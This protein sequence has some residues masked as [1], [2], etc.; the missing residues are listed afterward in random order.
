MK[1]SA[2]FFGLKELPAIDID[3]ETL[4]ELALK[5][6][7]LGLTVPGVQ[8]KLSLY[9]SHMS[10]CQLCPALVHLQHRRI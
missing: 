2:D 7:S 1:C 4:E 8:K 5:S 9:G 6:S 3:K 10:G